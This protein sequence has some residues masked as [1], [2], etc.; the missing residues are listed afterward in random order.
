MDFLVE[1][2]RNL[3]LGINGFHADWVDPIM[4]TL[5]RPIVWLPLYLLLLVL[6]IKTYKRDSWVFFAAIAVTIAMSDQITSGIM[7]PL[8]ERLRPSH[9]PTLQGLVHVVDG[10]RG[11]R[12]G[13]SSGHAANTISV[14]VFFSVLLQAKYSALWLLYFWPFFM[15]YSR[16]YL[17]VHYPGDV[18]AGFAVG[19]LCALAGVWVFRKGIEA[20]NRRRAATWNP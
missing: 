14:A 15:A 20:L 3:F 17:G 6:V 2:D 18:L 12:F 19:I 13:F 8:F 4:V 5:T 1:F 7:K 16:I 9:E 10:Y 11:G